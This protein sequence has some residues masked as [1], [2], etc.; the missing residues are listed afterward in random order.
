M[1]DSPHRTVHTRETGLEHAPDHPRRPQEQ[2]PTPFSAIKSMPRPT[3]AS[4]TSGRTRSAYRPIPDPQ[5][6]E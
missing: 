1:T 4:R 6:D 3:S 2:T 5:P